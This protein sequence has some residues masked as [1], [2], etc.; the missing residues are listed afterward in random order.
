MEDV[1]KQTTERILEIIRDTELY[2][3]YVFH[4][5]RLM[6][7]PALYEEL[8]QFRREA[9]E[10]KNAPE[11]ELMDRT[12]AFREKYA[13]F[14]ENPLVDDFLSAEMSLVRAV[15]KISVNVINALDIGETAAGNMSG[16]DQ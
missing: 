3:A 6:K 10:L 8:R 16:E 13:T 4:R 11:A 9:H 14:L 15:Q 2:R 12:D 7:Q 5:K 1:V